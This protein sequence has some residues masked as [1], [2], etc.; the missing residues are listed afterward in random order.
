MSKIA[1]ITGITGQDGSYLAELLLNKNYLVHGIIR[2]EIK[3]KNVKSFW[4]IEKIIKD[5][6]LHNLDFNNLNQLNNL[7]KKINPSEVYH[8][9][10]QAYDGHSFN[11]EFYTFN[12][13][14]NFTHK[15]LSTVRNVNPKAKFFFAG[16]SEMYDKETKNKIDEK[17]NFNPKSAYG[18]AKV[19]SHYLVKNYRES[20]NFNASTGILFNHESPRKDERFV[21]RKIAKSVVRIKLGLQKIILLGDIRSKRDWGHAKDYAKAMWLIN[22]QK[23]SSDYVIGTG[24]LNSVEDFVKKA[25]KHVD[26]NYK[27][28]LKI[29]KKLFR[30]KDSKA[31]LANPLK[32]TRKLKWKRKFNFESLVVDMV[33]SELKKSNFK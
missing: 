11:N 12:I 14:L 17:T 7:I 15:L 16:S 6:K 31:R 9:A 20:F 22:T 19:A 24:R 13:N 28:Y 29:D 2:N 32:L 25:F 4:R 1:L 26:L 33:E 5:L 30:K 10:A 21:L 8:L 27:K 23:K 3:K 18:I